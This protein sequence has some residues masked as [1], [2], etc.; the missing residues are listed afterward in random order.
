MMVGNDMF[1]VVSTF[2][3]LSFFICMY[4]MFVV[5]NTQTLNIFSVTHIVLT[6]RHQSD[7]LG[8]Q[9]ANLLNVDMN[10]CVPVSNDRSCN[11]NLCILHDLHSPTKT[12]FLYNLQILRI[13]I[14]LW[15]GF[16]FLKLCLFDLLFT[17]FNSRVNIVHAEPLIFVLPVERTTEE[18][19]FTQDLLFC[20]AQ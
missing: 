3:M 17:I 18:L 14:L 7:F 6:I 2:V 11:Y 10:V 4:I 13:N 5:E 8:F 15:V 20:V 16:L 12:K 19:L 9:Q 1:I